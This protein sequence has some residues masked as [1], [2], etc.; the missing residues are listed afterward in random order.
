MH[1]NDSPF[2][3]VIPTLNA[4]PEFLT[5]CLESIANQTLSPQEVLIV[6]N[7]EPGFEVAESRLSIRIIETVIGAGVAQARNIG[8]TL[9][10]TPYIAFL[11]DDDLWAP[12]YLELMSRHIAEQN[13]DGL[14][15][16]LDQLVGEDV[17]PFKNAQGS[18]NME[19]ILVRNPGVTGSSVV[20]KRSAF[21]KAGGYS[22]WL[23]AS[24][25]KALILEMMRQKSVIIAV[26]ECQAIVRQHGGYRLTEAK[27]LT[28]GIL[29]FHRRYRNDMTLRQKVFNLWKVARIA[30]KSRAIRLLWRKE[31]VG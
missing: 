31:P 10:T 3:V 17:L 4:R 24:E 8:A 15:A 18:L 25:D 21:I 1:S 9:A 23:P 2:T 16:R 20:V 6:N 7:G 12:D 22:V 5:E 26:P 30:I 11:D 14:V 28:R 29:A 19:E 27:N 13:P